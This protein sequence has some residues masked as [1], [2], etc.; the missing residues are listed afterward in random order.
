MFAVLPFTAAVILPD[1]RRMLDA[2]DPRDRALARTRWARL[3]AVR[4]GLG[5]AAAAAFL[6]ATLQP[7]G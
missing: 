7:V 4:T 1:Q 6:W 5:L 3:H 2:A